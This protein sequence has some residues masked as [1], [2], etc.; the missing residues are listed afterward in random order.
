MRACSFKVA[1]IAAAV[2][3]VIAGSAARV[4]AV[5]FTI[6]ST[7]TGDIRATVPDGIIIDVTV[8]GDTTSNTTAWVI[9]INSPAHPNARLDVF[10][11]NLAV[12]SSLLSFNGFSPTGWTMTGGNNVPGSGSADFLFESNDPPGNGNNVTN[13]VNLTF[14]A[15][16]SSG[17]WTTAM[18]TNAPASTGGPQI[19]AGG[20]Q[21]GAHVRSLSTANCT[22][23]DTSGFATGNYSGPPSQVPEPA[24][25]MLLGLGLLGFAAAQQRR[26]RK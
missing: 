12:N 22:R 14:N 19:P 25:M 5:P 13:A 20:A 7:L 2:V 24:S 16:L 1:T 21:M 23:C 18:F 9:D 10:A 3:T 17:N 6:T 8:T 15:V 4:E 11:F 26:A